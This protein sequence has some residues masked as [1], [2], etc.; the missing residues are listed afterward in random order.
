[1]RGYR[2]FFDWGSSLRKIMAKGLEGIK[3]SGMCIDHDC[4]IGC[5]SDSGEEREL[6]NMTHPEFNVRDESA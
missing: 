2:I 6:R 5:I 3:E 4:F 1:M